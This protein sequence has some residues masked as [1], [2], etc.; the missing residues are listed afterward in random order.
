[1]IPYSSL[2]FE[3]IIFLLEPETQDPNYYYI[4]SK[5]KN[6]NKNYYTF[7]SLNK[8]NFFVFSLILYD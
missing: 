2:S 5:Y 8:R 6:I 3:D 1:M 7:C 4:Y